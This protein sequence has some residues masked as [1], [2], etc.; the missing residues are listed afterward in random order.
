M[1]LRRRRDRLL[2][3]RARGPLVMASMAAGHLALAQ[4]VLWVNDPVG[5]GAG[6]W[7]AAGLPL[8]ALLLLPTRMWVWVLAGVAAAELGGDLA[9]GYPLAAS[10]GWTLGNVAGPL[11]GATLVRRSGNRSGALVPLRRLLGFLAFAVV[12]GPVVGSA[13]G[14]MATVYGVGELPMSEVWPK[15]VV[16]D[17]LGVLIVAPVLLTLGV[18]ATRRPW[19]ETAPLA[20]GALAVSVAAFS[21]WSGPLE[22]GAAYLLIPFFT[23]AALR[24]GPRGTALL[25][26]GVAVVSVGFATRGEGPFTTADIAGEPVTVLQAFLGVTVAS[27]LVLAALVSELSDR[28]Q[29][30]DALRR[31]AR[32]DPLT[33]LPN[34]AALAQA[35]AAG[36]T[37]CDRG[38]ALLVCDI[39]HL[40]AINDTLGHRAGDLL[41]RRVAGRIV[42]SVR[43]QD[44][45]T[46][47]SG[48]EFVVLVR[49]VGGGPR[50]GDVRPH[51]GRRRPARDARRARGDH[52]HAVDRRRDRRA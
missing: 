51:H 44:L 41:I 24:Y 3:V 43:P 5:A 6:V 30:A 15:Y 34:R 50:P 8:A 14:S 19:R 4:L 29:V 38:T 13:I 16:G 11:V 20:L 42:D 52:A 9:H 49:D 25:S 23:W 28:D 18:R 36:Q 2:A 22:R 37:S 26:L 31:Q 32:L 7:P 48:D 33:G 45:V 12:A 27:A 39:D 17:A 1:S 35:L 10:I 47:I 21:E 40:K 46:R